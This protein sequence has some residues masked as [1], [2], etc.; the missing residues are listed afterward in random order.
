MPVYVY[1]TRVLPDC[2]ELVAVLHPCK[3]A[4]TINDWQLLRMGPCAYDLTT[5]QIG[6]PPG[7]ATIVDTR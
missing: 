5:A 4:P 2:R 3:S 1:N 7:S 6:M